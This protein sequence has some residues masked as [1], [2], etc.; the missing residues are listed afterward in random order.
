MFTRVS[1]VYMPFSINVVKAQL[2]YK[3]A[4]F[5]FVFGN[6]LQIVA[7]MLLWSA[8]YRN[9]DTPVM[10]GFTSDEMVLYIFVNTCLGYWLIGSSASQSISRQIQDGSIAMNLI[11]PISFQMYLLFTDF[12]SKIT[13]IVLS[14][15]P[16]SIV[17]YIVAQFSLDLEAFS[18]INVSLCFVSIVLG[19]ITMFLF[20]CCF[21]FLAFYTQ[22]MWGLYQI[23]SA[24]L[25]FLSG[26]L[27]PFTFF[28]EQV[29][30]ILT[31][32]PFAS[33]GYTQTLILMGKFSEDM[34]PKVLLS[35]VIWLVIFAVMANLIWKHAIKRMVVLGG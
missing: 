32:S 23:K 18:I 10:N 13:N 26:A 33:L 17:F 6:M 8:I 29:E 14:I 19:F 30:K 11:K 25:L 9:S 28:P 15:I 2:I 16:Y 3:S 21:G 35:Q 5:F 12:G 27:V 24:L 7:K 31:F 20:E 34:I 22:Y 4:I 1:R